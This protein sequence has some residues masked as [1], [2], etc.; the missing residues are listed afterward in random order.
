MRTNLQKKKEIKSRQMKKKDAFEKK[1]INTSHEPGEA[2][3]RQHAEKGWDRL[4]K[5]VKN[6]NQQRL[7]SS[8]TPQELNLF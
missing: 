5:L 1:L 7:R 2:E 8:L 6:P 3:V 4:R